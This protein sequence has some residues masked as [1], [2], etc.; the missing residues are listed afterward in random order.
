MGIMTTTGAV[1][2]A[3]RAIAKHPPA[4]WM[5]T[6][7]RIYQLLLAKIKA[8]EIERDMYKEKFDLERMMV[9]NWK[10]QAEAEQDKGH[11]EKEAMRL[12]DECKRLIKEFSN[13][14]G[15]DLK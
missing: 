6:P 11:W 2:A 13:C 14:I 3:E 8:V 12:S 15:D 9:S 10:R 1:A 7:E 5:M 4:A